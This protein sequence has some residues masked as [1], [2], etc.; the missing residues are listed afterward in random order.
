MKLSIII[1]ILFS[2][3]SLKIQAED[4]TYYN[5]FE[6]GMPSIVSSEDNLENLLRNFPLYIEN[7]DQYEFL[8][9]KYV[10]TIKN[11]KQI[12]RYVKNNINK[13]MS[14]FIFITS[15]SGSNNDDYESKIRLEIHP[16]MEHQNLFDFK[17]FV[18][19]I[20]NEYIH[21]GYE[22]YMLKFVAN[23]KTYDYYIFINPQTK[24]VVTKG[25]IFGFNISEKHFTKLKNE[26]RKLKIE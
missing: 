6:Y 1:L 3:F 8:S 16:A 4:S 24:H 2:G 10:G 13:R 5:L 20:S 23:L 19:T 9:Y 15:I 14:V 25:N 26:K 7:A 17:S 22:V 18:D 11:R 12:K 21:P